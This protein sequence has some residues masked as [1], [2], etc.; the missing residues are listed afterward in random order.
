MK[1][2]YCPELPIE[3]YVK[4]LRAVK[5][6]EAVIQKR[7]CMIL[8]VCRKLREN[9]MSV[10]PTKWNED[11]ADYIKDKLIIDAPANV[12]KEYHYI[13]SKY[14][15][16]FNN[17]IFEKVSAE[18]PEDACKVKNE[19]TKEDVDKIL[20]EATGVERI[21][22]HMAAYLGLRYTEMLNLRLNDIHYDHLYIARKDKYGVS[23]RPIIFHSDTRYELERY[24]QIRN[25]EINRAK[26]I[27]ENIE[28]SNYLLIHHV[29]DDLPVYTTSA[30]HY[31]M[32]KLSDRSGVPFSIKTL[33]PIN[34]K[35]ISDFESR[36]VT[37]HKDQ[38]TLDRYQ[39]FEESDKEELAMN[40]DEFLT[41]VITGWHY[42]RKGQDKE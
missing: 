24:L 20:E 21:I 39:R 17:H 10:D 29:K 33:K 1:D 16:H 4:H 28:V 9:G 8:W 25:S 22:F 15:S 19:L 26:E 32:K 5:I 2:E 36:W 30:I 14:A 3:K 13:L 7:K 11:T 37:M 34:K 42:D 41:S 31:M 12:Y 18:M 40:G 38:K 35:N 27:N 6:S 23:M